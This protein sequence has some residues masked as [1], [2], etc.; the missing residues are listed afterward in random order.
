MTSTKT[1]ELESLQSNRE[2]ATNHK[3]SRLLLDAN[4]SVSYDH[5]VVSNVVLESSRSLYLETSRTTIDEKESMMLSIQLQEDIKKAKLKIFFLESQCR[6][7]GLST[8]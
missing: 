8:K 6:K 1:V 7:A 2:S 4:H 3:P 5:E